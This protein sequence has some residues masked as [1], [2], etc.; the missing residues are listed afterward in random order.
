MPLDSRFLIIS[1]VVVA[2][3]FSTQ[4]SA[5][6]RSGGKKID[7]NPEPPGPANCNCL[8]T[9]FLKKY[10]FYSFGSQCYV[11]GCFAATPACKSP[12][13]LDGTEPEGTVPAGYLNG[14]MQLQEADPV[15]CHFLES[16]KLGTVINANVL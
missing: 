1:S 3:S 9:S 10:T 15:F 14:T 12:V 16:E 5:L 6:D 11:Y 13:P 2:L 8:V 4:L 7:P